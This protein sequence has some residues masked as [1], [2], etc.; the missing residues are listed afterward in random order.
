MFSFLG[1]L[2]PP[3]SGMFDALTRGVIKQT[4]VHRFILMGFGFIFALPFYGVWLWLEGVPHVSS[5]FW[6]VV[7][8]HVPLMI[9][10][11]VLQVEAHRSSPLILTAPYLALTPVFI[12]LVKPIFGEE[13]ITAWGIIGV[14]M[15]TFGLYLLNTVSG[16]QGLLEPWRNIM[17]V[18]GSRLM[19]VSAFLLSFTANLDLMAFEKSSGA[20]YVLIDH[21][22][23]GCIS[24][25]LAVFYFLT[26]RATLGDLKPT[27]SWKALMLM[28]ALL[29]GSVIPH[30]LAFRWNQVVAYVVS[31][32]RTGMI[33][34]SVG[35]GIVIG[36]VTGKKEETDHLRWR[37]PGVLLMVIGMIIIICFGS[38]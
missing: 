23:I 32:K 2:L 36:L 26:G 28:G 14:V 15:V 8:I 12:L 19:L 20:Y 10:N 29:A 21:A 25:G 35:L 24:L 1:W 13:D 34:A 22:L 4:T 6:L 37:L 17:R 3:L 9:V 18:R 5:G 33:I 30:I 16:K 31:G 11:L 38:A 7:A 27:G